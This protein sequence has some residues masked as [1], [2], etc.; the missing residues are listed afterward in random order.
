MTVS[1]TSLKQSLH[2]GLT[3]VAQGAD[4][5]LI[6]H[7]NAQLWASH[8]FNQLQGLEAIRRVWSQLRYALPDMQRRDQIFVA[9]NSKADARMPDDLEGRGLVA[10]MG[11]YQGSFLNDL[12]G[13][14][15]TH[16]VVNLRVCEVHHLVE[17]K[18]AQSYVMLDLL[19][20]MGQAGC[21]PIAPS[22]G[23]EGMW[24]G[25]ATNDGVR[26]HTSDPAGGQT[27]FDT[28]I[29]MHNALGSF[30]GKSLD[31][32]QHGA[33]WADNFLWYGPSGI[34]QTRGMTGFRAHHQIPFL[35]GY[36][37]RKGAGHYVR[38]GDGDYVVTGGWPSVTGTHLG[39]WLGLPATGKHIEMRV[40]DFYRLENGVIQEN[41]IPIDILWIFKQM[42]L[43]VLARL[44]HLRGDP[45]TDL[46]P[47]P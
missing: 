41:W 33:Y 42:G 12:C 37:D 11:H 19:D 6:Y 8:P 34:G 23:A 17:G 13:I 26:L 43:D 21:W 10:S 36:P 18:I 22:L 39:E 25:P 4:P 44:R 3:A 2:A 29:A 28:V 9:G 7:S 47:D 15:A 46:P 14:P 1:L 5:A 30:D 32:M 16:G 27:A 40:M 31:S 24:S 20:L 38:I 45:L 35:V